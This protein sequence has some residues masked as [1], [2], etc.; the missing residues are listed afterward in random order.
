MTRAGDEEL[1]L[2]LAILTEHRTGAEQRAM[3]RVA[4]RLDDELNRA[5]WRAW[6][7]RAEVRPVSF[8]EL[9]VAATRRLS[10]GDRLVELKPRKR[11]PWV[12]PVEEYAVGGRWPVRASE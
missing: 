6:V 4:R 12:D 1:V 8:L 2:R 7:D 3:L 5:R 11:R 10:D 9:E